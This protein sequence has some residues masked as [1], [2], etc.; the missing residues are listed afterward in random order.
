MKP[1]KVGIS[2]ENAYAYVL[3]GSLIIGDLVLLKGTLEQPPQGIYSLDPRRS[4][5]QGVKV[6]TGLVSDWRPAGSRNLH[7]VV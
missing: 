5:G 6:L 7:S 2:L 3:L 4:L 1:N